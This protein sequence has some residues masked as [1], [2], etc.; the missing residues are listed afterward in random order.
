VTAVGWGGNKASF[1]ALPIV[2]VPAAPRGPVHAGRQPAGSG[3]TADSTVPAFLSGAGI[4]APGQAA[5]AA[6]LGLGLVRMAIPWQPGETAPDPT[7]VASLQSLPSQVGLVLELSASQLPADDVGRAQLAG[8][9]AS[10]AKQAPMLHYLTLTPAPTLATAPAYADAVAAIRAAVQAERPDAEVGPTVDGSAAQPQ[11]TT[12]ALAQELAR[13]ST[14]P[15]VVAFRPAPAVGPGAW[16]TYDIRQLEAAL[17]KQ[18]GTAPPVLLDAVATPATVPP[19]EL[20]GY[21]GGAPPTDGA[22]S[23]ATQASTY[24]AVLGA[25]SCSPNVSGLLFDR[26]A[27]DAAEPA[28]ATGLYYAGGDPKP[29]AAAVRRTIGA[30]DRGAVVCPGVATL[31]TPTALTFPERLGRSSRASVTLGCSRDCLYLV[32]LVGV[33]GRPVVARRGGLKGGYPATTI[34][35]PKRRLSPGRYRVDVRLVSRFDPGTV[36]RQSSPVLVVP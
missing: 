13:E 12:L 33:G 24:A 6:S 11:R 25:A 5:Q 16:T 20:S 8:Y 18:L 30:I 35:L 21:A 19:S 3:P 32:T 36:T 2:R 27:D 26:L 17:A 4:A 23:P 34:A 14:Q 15:D 7:T 29:A 31:V 9:A 28:P 1:T 10:L 22:V